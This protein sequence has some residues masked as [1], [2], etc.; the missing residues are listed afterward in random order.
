MVSP[1]YI[2]YKFR[3]DFKK[4]DRFL[5]V[6]VEGWLH[7]FDNINAKLSGIGIHVLGVSMF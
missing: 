3:F 6:K 5:S 7:E 4:R 1:V 2:T